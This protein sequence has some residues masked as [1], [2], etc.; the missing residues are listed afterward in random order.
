MAKA[1]PEAAP[2]A[3]SRHES[4]VENSI[5]IE[6]KSQLEPILGNLPKVQ[7][8][9]IL[10][11]VVSVVQSE[12]Y[13]GPLPHPRHWRE[14][15]EI[16]PG[17]AERILAMTEMQHSHN[18][19]I[20]S[21]IVSCEIRDRHVGMALGFL[22]FVGLIVLAYFAGMSDKTVLAGLLLGTA[23]VGGVVAFIKGRSQ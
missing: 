9:Q 23:A 16:L 5:E 11:K 1:P 18:I 4:S 19:S 10:G 20:Q 13:S 22:A 15:N 14:Y 8:E 21:R 6:L 3:V 2:S 7:R 12:Q 17:S